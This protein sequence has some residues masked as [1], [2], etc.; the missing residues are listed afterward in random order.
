L[1]PRNLAP[2]LFDSDERSAERE[3]DDRKHQP[4]VTTTSRDSSMITRTHTKSSP[5]A[6]IR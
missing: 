2:G 1:T 6:P 5:L 3:S 4:L